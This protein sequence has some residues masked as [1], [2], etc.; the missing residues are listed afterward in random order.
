MFTVDFS[1]LALAAFGALIL[2]V[3]T[4]GAAVGPA[5]VVE[6]SPLVYSQA[7]ADADHA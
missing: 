1:R 3:T 5:R 7:D 2:T 6:T 4:V